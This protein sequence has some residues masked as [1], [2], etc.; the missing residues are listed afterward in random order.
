VFSENEAI[1]YLAERTG[2]NDPEGA[3]SLAVE[4]GGLPL[5]LAQAAA[6]IAAQHLTYPAYLERL[7]AHHAQDYLPPTRGDPYPRGVAEA[8]LLSVD[9]MMASDPS[10]LGR[11]LLD[12]ISLLSPEGVT[13]SI[14][15]LGASVGVW[16]GGEEAVDEALARLADVSLLTFSGDDTVLAH[17]M[18]TRVIRDRA[19]YD[20]TLPALGA[21]TA[22]L[23][24]ARTKSFG[25]SE[26]RWQHRTAALECLR[27]ITALAEHLATWRAADSEELLALRLWVQETAATF[28][29]SP[30]RAIELGS[31]LVLDCERV[32]GRS[33]KD[34]LASRH[35]LAVAYIYAGRFDEAVSLLEDVLRD[36]EPALGASHPDI[37]SARGNLALAYRA[38]GRPGE[39][40]PL[41]QSVL[42]EREREQGLSHPD[43][44]PAR[45][46]LAGTYRDLG[47]LDEAAQL[48]EAVLA[49][50][51]HQ[52]GLSHPWTLTARHNLAR[53]YRDAG[54]LDEAVPLFEAALA[55][56]EQVMGMSHPYTLRSRSHLA[57]A[58][59]EAGRLAEAL[60]LFEQ[61]L[62]G[63]VA[64]LGA[65]HPDTIE[66]SRGLEKARELAEQ[67]GDLPPKQA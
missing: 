39:A 60:P 59:Q 49:D 38:A 62:A 28:G 46:N 32:L 66:A 37:L 9:A 57:R 52:L 27:Q 44:L 34:T 16:P 10:K 14:L 26:D 19:A 7:R 20:E 22:E 3:R 30:A 45:N 2:R 55:G 63:M 17:R 21:K 61:A 53:V 36:G 47:Q 64:E 56:S 4:L 11:D 15:Y 18:V 43:L 31:Q 54:R 23:L 40:L 35:H 12:V 6:V 67:D 48:F 42:T 51:E 8:I 58:Y 5:A 65:E 33:H 41:F 1:A 13:R 24:D 29:D 50:C 25:E